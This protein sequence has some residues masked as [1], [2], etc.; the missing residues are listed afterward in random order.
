MLVRDFVGIL[1][2]D[3]YARG[4]QFV[5]QRLMLLTPRPNSGP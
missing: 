3:K 5:A 1:K 4:D 2:Y